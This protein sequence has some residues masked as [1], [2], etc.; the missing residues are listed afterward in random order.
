MTSE[1]MTGLLLF[2]KPILWTS[3][4]A[5]DFIRRRIGQ[6]SVGHAGTLDPMASGLLIMLLGDA[7]KRFEQ[8]CSLEKEYQGSMLLGTATD[9]QDLDGRIQSEI[10]ADGVEEGSLQKIFSKML[11]AQLQTPPAYSAAKK[12]GKKLYE[13]ARKGIEVAMR[14]K[15][16]FISNFELL[17]FNS[18]E[19]Y[20]SMTCS[21]GTYVRT[22]CDTIGRRLGCGA[23]LSALVRTRIGPFK[24]SAALNEEQIKKTKPD[25]LEK[26]LKKYSGTT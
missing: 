8:L 15:E 25:E 17:N 26:F 7:T 14:P 21:K 5:V 1:T 3:H 23:T 9:T 4:D 13:F 10:L 22:I 19:V 16:I 12:D 18:P 24:L 20:F 2:D 11:G 6:R